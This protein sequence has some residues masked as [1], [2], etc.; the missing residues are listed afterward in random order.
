M[1]TAELLAELARR[2][3]TVALKDGTP[4]LRGPAGEATPTLLRALRWHRDAIRERLLADGPREWLW[5]DGHRYREHEGNWKDEYLLEQPD[6]HPAGAWW[7]RRVGAQ[8]W[9]PTPAG[10]A[11]GGGI[12]APAQQ[13]A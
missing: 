7:W 4:I 9:Q 3:L 5:R 1:S 11:H 10:L 8:A 6:R 13:A 12:A 2:G